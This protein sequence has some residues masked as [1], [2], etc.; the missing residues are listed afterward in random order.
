[1][2]DRIT[3][4]IHYIIAI[5]ILGFYSNP[6]W[7]AENK[8]QPADFIELAAVML[9]DGHNDRALLALQSVDLENK[10]TDLARFYTLQGLAYM[11]LNDLEAAKDSLQ[12][13][14]NK[15]QKRSGDFYLFGANP[16]R[17]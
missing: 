13:A 14:V 3:R 4:Q 10:K 12:Q 1:M 11:G 5:I 7:A 6:L 17:A 8:T 2:K 9:K 15:G 16:F